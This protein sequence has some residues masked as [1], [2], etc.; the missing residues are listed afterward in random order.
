MYFII[1]II[2]IFI[3]TILLTY[4]IDYV[5]NI[6]H[7]MQHYSEMEINRTMSDNCDTS[8][9]IIYVIYKIVNKFIMYIIS[10]YLYLVHS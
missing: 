2:I 6:N 7:T 3:I 10:Q 9:N 8:D 4:K 1:Y 5:I